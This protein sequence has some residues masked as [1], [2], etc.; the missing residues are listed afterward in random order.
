MAPS[1]SSG[2]RRRL[3]ITSV[4][5]TMLFQTLGLLL[6][7]MALYKH[8]CESAVPL[9]PQALPATDDRK[10]HGFSETAKTIAK[11]RS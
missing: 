7:V 1:S 2:R 9:L 3:T 10:T 6:S 11:I 4:L 8:S 5:V